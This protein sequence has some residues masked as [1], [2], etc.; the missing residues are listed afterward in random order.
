MVCWNVG[1][2]ITVKRAQGWSRSSKRL[3]SAGQLPKTK[4]MQTMDLFVMP[5]MMH[6][7]S[8][9]F[10]RN[11]PRPVPV[12]W[13]PVQR[14]LHYHSLYQG[15]CEY[16]REQPNWR[17][18]SRAVRYLRVLKR[19]YWPGNSLQRDRIRWTQAW[20]DALEDPEDSGA[21]TVVGEDD[22]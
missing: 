9:Y 14:D 18:F 2:F 12:N 16:L 22:Y 20:L 19:C 15:V 5:R 1:Y 6:F 8:L 4:S 10:I 13:R 21:E 7:D 3:F 11:E 17:F